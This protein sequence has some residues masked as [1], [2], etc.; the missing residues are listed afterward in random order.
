MEKSSD[1]IKRRQRQD[2]CRPTLQDGESM[3][4][5]LGKAGVRTEGG[6]KSSRG[7]QLAGVRGPPWGSWCAWGPHLESREEA[8]REGGL[9][10]LMLVLGTKCQ[11]P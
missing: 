5:V 6:W 2:G 4:H 11:V 10:E 9:G 1:F 3:R 7:R 8:L